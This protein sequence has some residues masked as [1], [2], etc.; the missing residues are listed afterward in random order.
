M[1]YLKKAI[2]LFPSLAGKESPFSTLAELYRQEG[3][4]EEELEIR[5]EWWSRTPLFIDNS[6]RL[7]E[8][9]EASGRTGDAKT[10]LEEAMYLDPFSREAHTKLGRLYMKLE[11]PD[12]AVRE[13]EAVL[14]LKPTNQAEAHFQLADAL[15]HA[16]ARDAAKRQVLLALENAPG[17]ERA[18]RLLLELVQR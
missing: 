11:E 1:T 10:L 15:Y 4:I 8:L 14:S 2:E 16:G 12:K 6:I 17:W 13:Y 5:R 18:Q 9:L 3:Q 7:A